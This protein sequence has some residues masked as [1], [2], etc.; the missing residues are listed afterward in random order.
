LVG[1]QR[2]TAFIEGTVDASGVDLPVAAAWLLVQGEEGVDLGDREA[3][4]ANRPIDAAWVGAQLDLLAGRG[5]VTETQLTASGHATA[6]RLL[7]ANRRRLTALVADWSY[8][9]DPRVNDAI[10]RLAEELAREPV[11]T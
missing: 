5:L 9:D 4:T 7:D 8:D 3:I 11:G 1:R 10:T 2:T 6:E